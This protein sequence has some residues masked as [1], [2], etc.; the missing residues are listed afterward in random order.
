MRNILL[1]WA[2]TFPVAIV[3][4]SNAFAVS[5]EIGELI[6]ERKTADIRLADATRFE[7]DEVY[8]FSPYTSRSDVCE[9]LHIQIRHCDRHVHFESW[10]DGEMSLAFVNRGRLVHY[11]RH[12]RRNGDFIP[13]PSRQ[14]LAVAAAVFRLVPEGVSKDQQTSFKLVLK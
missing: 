13:V 1:V 10:D 2:M 6:R 3:A 14:P 5:G 8:L 12:S 11:A 4:F 7:W 9:T